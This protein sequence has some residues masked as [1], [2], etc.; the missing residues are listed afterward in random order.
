MPSNHV[1]EAVS[2]LREVILAGEQ[3]RRKAA[4]HLGLSAS[5]SQAVSYLLS[6]GPMGQTA[7]AQALGFNTS[8]T[9]ALIDRL[10]RRGI[11][12]RQPDPNDRR[13]STVRLSEDGLHALGDVPNWMIEAF[14]TFAPSELPDITTT[15][16]TIAESLRTMPSDHSVAIANRPSREA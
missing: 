9:T 3:Y 16:V 1:S 4:S 5:E 7:L 15:L 2:A 11:A 6:R 12:E 10:E 14:E 13:R 8:S